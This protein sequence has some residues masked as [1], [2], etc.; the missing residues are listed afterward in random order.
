MSAN[1]AKLALIRQQRE[2]AP[3]GVG[4]GPVYGYSLGLA[5]LGDGGLYEAADKLQ[6]AWDLALRQGINNPNVFPLAGDLAEALA[7]AGESDR[8]TRVVTWLEERSQATGLA[9]PRAVACRALGILATEPEEAQ[10]LFAE[11]LAALDKV[12]PIAFEQARTLLCSGEAM[13]R[14]RRPVAAR[15]PL[16]EALTL[17][18]GLGARPWAARARAEL[19][20]SGVKDQRVTDGSAAQQRG[21]RSSVRRNCRLPGLPHEGR[22]ISR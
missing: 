17:F 7:R 19:A 5:A 18:E 15:E 9:Y 20:A 21:F 13:R 6:Q 2:V 1:S 10:R 11:S 14:N 4:C 8:C 3:R 12:G 22:T 16:H